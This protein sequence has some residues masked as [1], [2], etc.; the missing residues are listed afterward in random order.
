MSKPELPLKYPQFMIIG[1]G[2]SG[3]TALFEY[4]N[5]HPD[6][7]MPRVKET[8]FMSLEGKRSI[9]IEEDP[10]MLEYYP[11]S[12]FDMETYLGLYEDCPDGITAGEASPM[13]LYKN[14]AH[15]KIKEYCPEA[16]MIAIFRNPAERLYSRYLHLAREGI[17]P[18]GWPE[19]VFDKSSIWWRRD[20]LLLEGYYYKHLSKF[21]ETFPRE[22]FKIFL[23]DDL[24]NN[25]KQ[26]IYDIFEFI[27]VDPDFEPDTSTEHNKS[28]FIKNKFLNGLIGNDSPLKNFVAKV[29]PGFVESL[30]RNDKLKGRVLEAR[31]KNLVRPKYE[32]EIKKRITDEIYK[33]DLLKFEKL[34]G[35]DISHWYK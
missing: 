16:K 7:F 19:S 12:V 33:E 35:R 14:D 8:N 22:Q 31:N 3:T 21:M 32:A 2:K 30:R 6:V 23:Y 34:I 9:P 4:L 11:H 17:Q 24:R 5:Q 29:A 27:G 28:G 26:V 10:E 18:E 20:D 1:A 25:Q 15:L 13:Y